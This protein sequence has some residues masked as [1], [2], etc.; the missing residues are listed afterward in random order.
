MSTPLNLFPFLKSHDTGNYCPMYT[1][2]Y[3]SPLLLLTL[4]PYNHLQIYIDPKY[5]SLF[6]PIYIFHI[7]A[8][9]L[10]CMQ[11]IHLFIIFLPQF[12]SYSIIAT[13]YLDKNPLNIIN[14]WTITQNDNITSQLN[15]GA[16]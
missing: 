13:G 16:R 1:L 2:K 10:F 7:I 11:N 6:P 8:F 3:F 15:C 14:R 9:V 5:C 12:I 4:G